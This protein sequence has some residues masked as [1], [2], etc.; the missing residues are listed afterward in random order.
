M[1]KLIQAFYRKFPHKHDFTDISEYGSVYPTCTK[2]GIVWFGNA[3]DP[4]PERSNEDVEEEL[5]NFLIN[6]SNNKK[7]KNK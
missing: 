6:L 3:P 4:F 1:K 2:C 5:V 7:E